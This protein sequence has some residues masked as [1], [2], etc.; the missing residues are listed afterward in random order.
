MPC[1]FQEH[2]SGL[3]FSS[4]FVA[5]SHKY[6]RPMSS[7]DRFVC[8]QQLRQASR[9][10]RLLTLL[11]H[12]QHRLGEREDLLFSRPP[13]RSFGKGSFGKLREAS[14]S[15]GKLRE[16]AGSFGKLREG[17]REKRRCSLSPRRCWICSR[18][19]SRRADAPGSL[20][21]LPEAPR[22]S[23]KLQEASRSLP[24]LPEATQR[25]RASTPT[26]H[27]LHGD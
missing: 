6:Q 21:K 4:D 11:E 24:K 5:G 20:P 17:G 22:G 18:R 14:G 7:T 15:F 1:P 12:I 10:A 23:G 2:S 26:V 19:L 8:N 13:S 27:V 16:A 9:S 25:R 3:F